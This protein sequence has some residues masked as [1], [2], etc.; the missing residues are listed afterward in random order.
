V[1][2]FERKQQ[3]RNSSYQFLFKSVFSCA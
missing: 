1:K 3:N 2:H